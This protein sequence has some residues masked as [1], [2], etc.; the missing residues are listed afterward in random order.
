[1]PEYPITTL[2]LYSVDF[3]SSYKNVRFFASNYEKDIYFGGYIEPIH[4]FT[5]M[6]YIRRNGIVDVPVSFESCSKVNYAVYNNGDKKEYAF[7]KAV[8]FLNFNCTRLTLQYDVFTNEIDNNTEVY[9]SYNRRTYSKEDLNTIYDG[10]ANRVYSSIVHP[11]I[12]QRFTLVVVYSKTTAVDHIELI[13]FKHQLYDA[14]NVAFY[15][16]DFNGNPIDDSSELSVALETLKSAWCMSAFIIPNLEKPQTAILKT[17]K[18]LKNEDGD[19]LSEPIN[20]YEYPVDDV[21]DLMTVEYD[22]NLSTVLNPTKKLN[23]YP[24]SDFVLTDGVNSITIYP[25]YLPETFTIEGKVKI[26]SSGVYIRYVVPYN[27]DSCVSMFSSNI[28]EMPVFTS[29]RNEYIQQNSASQLSN[30]ISLL[31]TGNVTGTFANLMQGAFT[32]DIPSIVK[33]AGKISSE[34]I[35]SFAFGAS[36]T[37]RANTMSNTEKDK[38]IQLW[39]TTGYPCTENGRL[40]FRRHLMYDYIKTTNVQFVN[41]HDDEALILRNAL[42]DGVTFWHFHQGTFSQVGKYDY[43]EN[44]EA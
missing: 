34:S 3:D 16:Y 2:E 13:P 36:L 32:S 23:T 29:E 10:P 5:G 12:M 37:I 40:I 9:C 42:N 35:S 7:V 18:V 20:A 22:F 31:G 24:Y 11:Q 30:A 43:E 6:M 14:L 1:M 33:N 21:N 39:D 19:V 4:E 15:N 27:D 44:T 26:D 8:E 25:E 38:F 28:G 41:I 17:F